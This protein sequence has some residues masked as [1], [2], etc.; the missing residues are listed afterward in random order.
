MKNLLALLVLTILLTACSSNNKKKQT[1]TNI[2]LKTTLD[3]S[4]HDWV[5]KTLSEL[6][7]REMAGQ[8]VLEWTAGSYFAVG[9]EGYEEEVKIV[10]SGIGGLWIMGGHP[11]ERAARTNEL[12]KYAKVP[13]LVYGADGLGHKLYTNEMDKSW[14]RTGGTDMPPAIA[15]G[16]IGDPIAAKEAGRIIGL[17][18]RAIGLHCTEVVL[19]VPLSLKLKNLVSRTFGDD[20]IMVA[21]LGSAFIEGAHESGVIATSGFFPGGGDIAVDPHFKLGIDRS[22]R[23]THDSIHFVPFR[24]AIKKGTNMIMTSHFSS[25]SLTGLDSLPVTISPEITRILRED[26][27]YNGVL[28]TDAM[29]MGGIRNN[30]DFIEAAV[31]AFKAGNDI[32]LGTSSIKFCD[33]LTALVEKGEIPKERLKNSVRRILELKA[34]LGLNNNRMVDLYDINTV[35]GNKT[36]QLKAD[37]AAT[38][39]IVLL[40]DKNTKVPL[41]TI[42][43]NKTLSITY[44]GGDNNSAGNTFNSVLHKHM[45]TVDAIKVTPSSDTSFYKRL[46]ERCQSVD[47]VILSVYSKPSKSLNQLIENLQAVGKNVTLISFGEWEVLNILPEIETLMMAWSKQDVM[48][49]AAAKSLLGLTPISGRLPINIPPFHKTGDGIGRERIR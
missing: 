27:G 10:E 42:D 9:S 48:Q 11:Y 20:P 30:Y 17:E 5:E 28:I 29:D 36:H 32:I 15:Y 14:L 12:Q 38:R 8:V 25:P 2:S 35:V 3:K 6:S 37:T 47:Q 43:S 24:A 4:Q 49:R 40:R 18:A 16:A 39:S 45:K 19:S 41:N 46:T 7:I 26:L 13:L 1:M 44:T 34:K 23:Q 31:L 21:Q 33:T 22:V